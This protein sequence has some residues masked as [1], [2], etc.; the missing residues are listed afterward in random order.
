MTAPLAPLFRQSLLRV[1]AHPWFRSL[2]TDTL[3]GRS[4][5]KRFVAGSSLEDAMR[6]A[7]ELDRYRMLSMLDH[8]GENV[9][10]ADQADQAARDY[11]DAFDA[12]AAAPSL[13]CA[14]SIKL[15]QL[16]LDDSVEACMARVSPVL[17]AATDTGALVMID[18]ESHPYVDDTLEVLRRAHALYPKTGVCLQAYLKRTVTDIFELPAGVRVRLVK[19]AY[20]EPPDVVYT[21]KDEVD[22]RWAELFTTLFARGHS[23][24]AAT[25]DPSLVE[26]VRRV[27]EGSGEGWSRVEFQMLYGVRRDLQAKLAQQG[28]PLRVYIPYGTDWYPYLTRRLAERPANLWFFLSNAVRVGR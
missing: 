25:H 5:A 3:P 2:A 10:T 28:Y 24:D 23:I 9:Q 12:I 22:Q 21:A 6:V 11:L 16:G 19:G 8:L 27:V 7:R 20:L 4:V 1:A 13:D 18:M 26:G 14:A 17:S 15:T